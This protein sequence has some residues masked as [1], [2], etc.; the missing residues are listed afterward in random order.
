MPSSLPTPHT[1]FNRCNLSP[2]AIASV[3]FQEN[4]KLLE[5]DN[6][7]ATDRRLFAKLNQLDDPARR[8][9]VFLDYVSVKFRLHEWAE[10]QASARSSLHSSYIQ[11]LRGWGADSNGHSG[12]VLKSWVESRFG[13]PARYHGGRLPDDPQ[14]CERYRRDCM[15]GAAKTVA[16]KKRAARR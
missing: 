9:E 11:F 10:H 7:R 3:D 6:I 1:V 4:P 5:I 15:K 2:W 14:A 12:A 13:L 16:R 8:V